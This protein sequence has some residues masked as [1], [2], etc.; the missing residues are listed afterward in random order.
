[1]F[2]NAGEGGGGGGGGGGGN[3]LKSLAFP[4]LQ[5][6][7]VNF[8]PLHV[9][10]H[11]AVVERLLSVYSETCCL[12]LSLSS[13]CLFLFCFYSKSQKMFMVNKSRQ[14]ETMMKRRC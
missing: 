8:H 2:W 5:N 12:F 11:I 1:M 3:K 13:L 7:W 10:F 4:G 14:R 6:L 9:C